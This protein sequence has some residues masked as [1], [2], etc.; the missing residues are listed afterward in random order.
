MRKKT[1]GQ[2][3]RRSSFK[4]HTSTAKLRQPLLERADI[5]TIVY[6]VA[7]QLAPADVVALLAHERQLRKR[8][9]AVRSAEM[10][11]LG[12]QVALALDCL[13]DHVDGACPQIPYYTISLL[14]AAVSYFAR[15]LD[16]IPDFLPH[17]GRLDDA[18]VM[19]L[20]F[21]LGREG[22]RRYCD[23]KGRDLD[24]VL[25]PSTAAAPS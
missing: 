1:P 9:A 20:A 15:E 18:V 22:L 3:A 23:W 10:H 21:Q 12:A 17:V 16:V 2:T 11:V 13:R 6:E 24:A 7:N 8:A 19:A 25:G 4:Q 14:A 5:R